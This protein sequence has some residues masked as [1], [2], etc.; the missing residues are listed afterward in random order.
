MPSNAFS[1]R[2]V[3]NLAIGLCF[4]LWLS[5]CATQPA[6][7][8]DG[9]WPT[10]GDP[11][12]QGFA[13]QCRLEL[14]EARVLFAALELQREPLS[15]GAFLDAVNDLEIVVNRIS[16]RS[17]LFRNVHPEAEVREAADICQQ[18]LVG[19]NTEISLSRPLYQRLNQVEVAALET[20][21][22]RYV[23]KMLEAYQRSGVDRDEATRERIREL[24]DE[25]NRLGQAFNRNIREDSRGLSVDVSRLTGLPDDFIAER[26]DDQG[27]VALST[28]YPDYFPVMQY[29][30]DDELRLELYK[31]FR[32]RAYPDNDRVLLELFAARYELAQLL[33]YDHY[34]HYV[35]E[36]KMIQTPE[37]AQ[38]FI[39]RIMQISDRRARD[40]YQQ[41]LERLQR[42]DPA[43][44]RVGDWQ[45]FY[46]EEL[47]SQ[48]DYAIDSREV[49]QYFHYDKVRQGLFNLTELLFGVT[50]EPWE[51]DVWHD[52]VSAYEIREND[53]LLGRFYLDMHPRSGKFN[54]AAAFTKQ[55]GVRDRQPPV[56]ALVCNFPTGNME[57]SDVRTFFHEWGHLIHAI[58]GGHQPRLSLS[59]I[60]TEWDFVEAPAQMFEEWIW[61]LE[62]LAAFAT[63]EQG[64]VIPE[65]LVANMNAARG[66]G[67]GLWVQHQMYYAALSL[68]YYN[69][70]PEGMDLTDKVRRYQAMY[71]PFPYVE[72]TYF[73]ATFGHLYGYSA[74]YYTYMWSLVIAADMFSEFEKH[75]MLNPDVAQR[76]RRTVLDPG[77]SRDAADLVEDFLGRPYGFDAFG[78]MLER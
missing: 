17:S 37:N 63:N 43:A 39:D 11:R 36:D 59:G 9:I 28:D 47:I 26:L 1:P 23:T 68:N 73:H 21:D 27:Q 22:Q 4:T 75:G 67:R 25:I 70:D 48:E 53:Q 29:A 35:T 62:T 13:E 5:G 7:P 50:I 51:V 66:F 8:E 15:D 24:N 64:E 44:E 2:G 77:G 3:G 38:A 40:D 60:R 12:A 6:E 41:L 71:S 76:W 57:H 54:H 78:R 18:Q 61:D 16:G 34:A 19:L 46:V 20:V 72:D 49:R 31:L 33:G 45:K 30:E 74:I 10:F 56:V 14:E 58:F 52:S 55:S 69:R 65:E 32:Q 42:I